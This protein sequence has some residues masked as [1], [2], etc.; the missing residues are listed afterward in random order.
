[1]NL[2]P[3]ISIMIILFNPEKFIWEVIERVFQVFQLE[4]LA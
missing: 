4:A 3:L 1:V 2:D